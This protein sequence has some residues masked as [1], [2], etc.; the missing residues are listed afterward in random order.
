MLNWDAQTQH[1][2]HG[3]LCKMRIAGYSLQKRKIKDVQS[4]EITL[5]S[6]ISSLT[7]L[8]GSLLFIIVSK[9]N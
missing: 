4:T 9:K 6:S 2:T 5:L 3:A 1:R 7:T 8:N